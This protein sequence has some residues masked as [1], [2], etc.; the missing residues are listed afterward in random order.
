[1]NIQNLLYHKFTAGNIK[2]N[3]TFDENGIA[4]NQ[5]TFN[6][7]GGQG[8]Y[9]FRQG[10]DISLKIPLRNPQKDKDRIAQ[11][12]KPRRNKGVIVYLRAKKGP[13]GK[14]HIGWDP[15][16]KNRLEDS[17]DDAPEHSSLFRKK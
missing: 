9:G 12:L 10:T 14:V 8:V 3:V 15:L 13:D 5:T 17:A 16:H 1:M 4:I 2:A 6:H 7:A 11:G